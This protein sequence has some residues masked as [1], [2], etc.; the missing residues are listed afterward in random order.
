LL[1]SEPISSKS[2][3]VNSVNRGDLLSLEGW[4]SIQ[5]QGVNVCGIVTLVYGESGMQCEIRIKRERS[6]KPFAVKDSLGTTEIGREGNP[7]SVLFQN[8]TAYKSSHRPQEVQ[9]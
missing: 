5:E 4:K 3:E 1:I 7:I 8:R 9:M 2:G 6:S